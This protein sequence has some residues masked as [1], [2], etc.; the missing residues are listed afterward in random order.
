MNDAAKQGSLEAAREII[1]T[2][3]ILTSVETS[4]TNSALAWASP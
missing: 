1:D 4:L 2:M 3:I